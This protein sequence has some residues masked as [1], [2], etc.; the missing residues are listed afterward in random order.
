MIYVDGL[1]F[2]DKQELETMP[3]WINPEYVVRVGV[4]EQEGLDGRCT[5]VYLDGDVTAVFTFESVDAIVRR[6]QNKAE[7]PTRLERKK[8]DVVDFGPK[9]DG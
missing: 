2:N 3:V 1:C 9:T 8:A 5:A 4:H 7:M 6:I